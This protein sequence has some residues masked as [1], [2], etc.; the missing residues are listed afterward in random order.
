MSVYCLYNKTSSNGGEYIEAFTKYL[1]TQHVDDITDILLEL[2]KTIHYSITINVLD[3]LNISQRLGTLLLA[4]P[5]EMLPHFDSA[6]L[7]AQRTIMKESP[8]GNSMLFKPFCHARLHN[9][10]MCSEIAKPT[11]S[12]IR[13]ND[14]HK[15]ISVP[16]TVIRTGGVKMLQSEKS[17]ICMSCKEQ[18]KMYSELEKGNVISKPTSCPS[19]DCTGINFK[20]VDDSEICRDYQEIKV[21]DKISCLHLGS[22][23]RSITVI[24]QDDLVDVCKPGDDVVLTG[25]IGPRWKPFRPDSRCEIEIIMTCNHVLINNASKGSLSVTED[26]KNEFYEFWRKG[27]ENPLKARNFIIKS[28]CP[29]IYGLYLVKLA[30]GLTLIGGV[31]ELKG[32]TRIR[33]ESHLL[34]VGDPG[35]G[36]SQFLKYASKLSPRNVLTNGIGTTSA[37][38]TVM[39]AKDSTGEWTL[40]AG[41]LV[42][43]DGGVC[44]IDEFDSIREHDRATI[45]EAMEQQTLSIAKAGLVCKLNSRTTVIAATN[46]KGKYDISSSLSVNCNLASP[47]LSR[48]DLVLILLDSQDEH[49]DT[50]V[51]N[52]IL[53]G[54]EIFTEEDILGLW[55]FEKLQNYICFVK[56]TFNPQIPKE[57]GKILAKYYQLQRRLSDRVAARTTIRLLESLVRIAQA[58]ARLMF[59]DQ[60]TIQDAVMAVLIIDSSMHASNL[61][62]VYS[63][64]HSEFPEDPDLDYQNHEKLVFEKLGMFTQDDVSEGRESLGDE[65]DLSKVQDPEEDEIIE[66]IVNKSNVSSDLP[67]PRYKNTDLLNVSDVD[68][69]V[70]ETKPFRFDTSQI[71]Q[72]TA[73][74]KKTNKIEVSFFDEEDPHNLIIPPILPTPKKRRFNILDD[75]DVPNLPSN[76]PFVTTPTETK[77]IHFKSKFLDMEE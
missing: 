6:I 31:A 1:V 10:P 24:L 75:E 13:S 60:V 66:E 34:L 9:L 41:A 16:G 39:A 53:K 77:K 2:E 65:F 27:Q 21:Q 58:H 22:I 18:F 46:P 68:D 25:L 3:L 28:M 57:S 56:N 14:I 29:Q 5:L 32:T 30:L 40:E 52:F 12:S 43:A 36:K 35:C 59:H 76:Q 73:D 33:G 72:I 69:V 49:W 64:L 62:G 74:P 55:T 67:S 48:F 19:G 15:F 7:E 45:H 47:L 8:D 26:L 23:P 17:F 61:V 44:C 42:L 11:V 50:K 4:Y 37:G 70:E 51:S 71:S 20:P 38:L 54:E 63:V